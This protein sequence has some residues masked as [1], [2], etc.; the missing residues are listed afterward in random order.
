MKNAKSLI[1]SAL[2]AVFAGVV[3]FG[4]NTALGS[5][6]QD[7]P[8]GPVSPTLSGL[9]MTG[10]ISFLNPSDDKTPVSS[11]Y[12]QDLGGLLFTFFDGTWVFNQTLAVQG[13][14]NAMGN[15]SVGG[16]LDVTGPVAFRS[17]IVTTAPFQVGAG[18]FLTVDK[19]SSADPGNGRPVM[20]NTPIQGGPATVGGQYVL[21]V[22][23]QLRSSGVFNV[24]GE[25]FNSNGSV[26]V[27]DPLDVRGSIFDGDSDLT[28]SDNLLVGTSTSSKNLQVYGNITANQI[29]RF[30]RFR[31]A[32]SVPA[33]SYN[34]SNQACPAGSVVVACNTKPESEAD[35]RY[36]LGIS[37]Y[38]DPD[39]TYCQGR[40][41]NGK[42]TGALNY[43]VEAIC[44]FPQG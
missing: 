36:Y 32:F 4:F 12:A 23:N 7:P 24:L 16:S 35:T 28:I 29:G 6:T 14:L 10:P 2:A 27:N 3:L 21:D 41:Y 39:L 40:M 42:S 15:V 22:K 38:A 37:S 1:I 18:Q 25:I 44:F 43:S 26:K 8:E 33:S 19:I 20:F 11:I 13:L 31:T 17:P 30:Q 9:N 34:T 5:P